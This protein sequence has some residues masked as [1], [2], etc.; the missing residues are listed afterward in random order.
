MVRSRRGTRVEMS[1]VLRALAILLIV[2]T[3]GNL[4][5]VPGGAHLLLAVVGYNFARF[6]L[7]RGGVDRLRSGVGS[8]LRLALPCMVWIGA[9]ALTIGTY[10]PGT[11]FFLN[12]LVGSDQWTVQWQFWFLEVIVWTQLI[13]LVAMAIPWLHRT[14]RRTPFMFA[15]T[16][17]VG[18]LAVR[19]A[20]TGIEAGATERYTPSIVLWCFMLGWVVAVARTHLQRVAVSVI[21][22]VA[23]VGFFDDILREAVIVAGVLLLVWVPAVR[24]PRSASRA[25]GI[26]AAASLYIYLTHWQIY[27]YL[28]DRIPVLAVLA[29][30]ALGLA[31]QAVWAGLVRRA[32]RLRTV[33]H[34]STSAG[35]GSLVAIGSA[36]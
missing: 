20:L 23:T 11:V 14:E 35:S 22:A 36:T 17:L 15:I 1:I 34:T 29:S 24:L 9:V 25:V 28:E 2:G 32:R 8:L 18:S 33:L 3:H 10:E 19:Y 16:V 13:A 26:L 12:G 6:Q 31:F 27:P 4:W 30:I 21:A 5:T 7:D